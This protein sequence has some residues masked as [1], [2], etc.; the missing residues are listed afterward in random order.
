M[1][2]STL[3]LG[4]GPDKNNKIIIQQKWL[5]LS[6]TFIVLWWKDDSYSHSL[7]FQGELFDQIVFRCFTDL[8][9]IIMWVLHE[10]INS[11]HFTLTCF[12][13][14]RHNHMSITCDTSGLSVDI[15]YD[16]LYLRNTENWFSQSF[17]S[18][19][20][21]YTFT[22]W[23]WWSNFSKSAK[24]PWICLKLKLTEEQNDDGQHMTYSR[25]IE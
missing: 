11:E 9:V 2:W 12:D 13:C 7:T 4:P 17:H 25:S 15:F 19:Q 16:H 22:S 6:Q 14:D 21:F 10:L 24:F 8:T 23:F 5:K 1:H 3:P 20:F 18:S